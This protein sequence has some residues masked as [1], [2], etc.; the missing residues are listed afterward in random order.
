M[1]AKPDSVEPTLLMTV[2]EVA[3]HLRIGR[4]GVYRLLWTDGPLGLRS[5]MVGKRRLIPRREVEQWITRTLG[6]VDDIA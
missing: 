2:A 3:R 6:E 4:D 1:K 5:L